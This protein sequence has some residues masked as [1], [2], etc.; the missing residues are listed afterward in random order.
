MTKEI[1]VDGLIFD[2]C[3]LGN[4]RTRKRKLVLRVTKDE[5][6]KRLTLCDEQEGIM[7]EVPVEP[8]EEMLREI[9]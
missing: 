4:A 3:R 9:L 7:T 6:S 2:M 5:K 1:E 8:I